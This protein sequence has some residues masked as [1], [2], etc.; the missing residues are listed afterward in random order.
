MAEVLQV[1]I[2][3]QSPLVF[4]DATEAFA[5]AQREHEAW[6]WL[7]DEA[8][9]EGRR[10]IND[11]INLARPAM[12]GVLNAAQGWTA[13][14]SQSR[15]DA[16]RAHIRTAF[17]DRKLPMSSDPVFQLA[18]HLRST[19]DALTAASALAAFSGK[20][21]FSD[22]PVPYK[23]LK[24]MAAAAVLDGTIIRAAA[25]CEASLSREQLEAQIARLQKRITQ[26]LSASEEAPATRST[27]Q[28]TPFTT[29]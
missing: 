19:D 10:S 26:K 21:N 5:W 8:V 11:L 2:G 28:P 12:S 22:Q 14:D 16:L 13:E 6:T 23:D 20:L 4:Q 18:H 3:R 24:G 29:S 7:T 1:D 9:Q 17:V 27:R 25:P 15:R